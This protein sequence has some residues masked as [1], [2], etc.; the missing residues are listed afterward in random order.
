M[1]M[2]ELAASRL[3]APHFGFSIYAWVTL[4]TIMMLALVVGYD[5]GGHYADC[6]QSDRP[7]SDVI[8]SSTFYQLTLA[9]F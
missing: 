7:L 4:L 2:P 6:G 8:L 3:H 1:M 9:F 5:L